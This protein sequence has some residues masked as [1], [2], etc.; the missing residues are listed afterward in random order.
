VLVTQNEVAF[1]QLDEVVSTA[2][3][4]KDIFPEWY[5]YAAA[6]PTYVG[7][8][9]AFSWPTDNPDL[10]R[11]NVQTLRQRYVRSGI[12]TPYYNPEVPYVALALPQYVLTAIGK[13]DNEYRC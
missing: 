2:G 6:V 8:I 7:R 3:C 4:L 11:T 12:K 10:R 9:M 1:P 5:F 13:I